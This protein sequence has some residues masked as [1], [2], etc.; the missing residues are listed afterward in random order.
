MT[1]L[2]Q[3]P[4]GLSHMLLMI[5]WVT[6]ECMM[7]SFFIVP[8]SAIKNDVIMHPWITIYTLLNYVY[9]LRTHAANTLL[10]AQHAD[11]ISTFIVNS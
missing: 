6:Q 7:T 11:I 5:I 1:A 2:A 3:T 9:A 10:T 8:P 4:S